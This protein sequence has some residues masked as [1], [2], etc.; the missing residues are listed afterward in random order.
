MLH[1]EKALYADPDAPYERLRQFTLSQL[2]NAYIILGLNPIADQFDGL[3]S[4]YN[5]G[6]QMA[7]GD[8][9]RQRI[10]RLEMAG[11]K[12]GEKLL[13]QLIARVFD[14]GN[15]PHSVDDEGESGVD[16]T[17]GAAP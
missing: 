10:E 14:A 1:F 7:S 12:V 4:G 6:G 16:S 9:V 8:W 15:R 3:I 5:H 17:T 2:Y 11:S 13:E